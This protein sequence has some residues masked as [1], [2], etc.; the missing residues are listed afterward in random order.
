MMSNSDEILALNRRIH[1][2]KGYRMMMIILYI[3]DYENY[4]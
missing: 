3:A 2:V 4:V 1:E